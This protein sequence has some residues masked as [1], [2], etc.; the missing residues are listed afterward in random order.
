MCSSPGYQYKSLT[1]LDQAD[2]IVAEKKIH[3]HA[4]LIM[5]TCTLM[6][7]SLCNIICQQTL[8]SNAV[9]RSSLLSLQAYCQSFVHNS[10]LQAILNSYLAHVLEL[11]RYSICDC[12]AELMMLASTGSRPG[13]RCLATQ[14]DYASTDQSQQERLGSKV[15]HDLPTDVSPLRGIL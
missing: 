5:F 15:S 3:K 4:R 14:K 11:N 9:Y 10:S 7:S 12:A 6:S 8:P 2:D 1:Y 13:S